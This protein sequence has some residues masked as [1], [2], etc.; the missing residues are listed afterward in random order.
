MIL[1]TFSKAYVTTS[2]LSFGYLA[3]NVA[4]HSMRLWNHY[5]PENYAISQSMQ[6]K[7]ALISQIFGTALSA[8]I[9][10]YHE[11]HLLNNFNQELEDLDRHYKALINEREL[12]RDE[13]FQRQLEQ[14]KNTLETIFMEACQSINQIQN[15]DAPIEAWKS[16]RAFSPPD[17]ND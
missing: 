5:I 10:L 3:K 7:L 9:L 8:S 2:A 17:F 11:K 4:R 12:I 16:Y 14:T 1:T 15:S 6:N 13:E